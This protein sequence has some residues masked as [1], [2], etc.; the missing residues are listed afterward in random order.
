MSDTTP[1]APHESAGLDLR[2][3]LALGAG[4]G[5]SALLA[6]CGG[7]K[8]ADDAAKP[9]A[10]ASPTKEFTGE[11]TGPNVELQY[12]NGFTGGDGPFMKKLVDTFN[13]EHKNIK[14]TMNTS[15]WADFY[16]KMPAAVQGGKGPDVVAMHMDAIPAN[17]ARQIVVPL[18]DVASG[19]KLEE[20][21]FYPL[22]WKAGVYKDQRYG[23][24]LD[25]H[26]LGM[27]YN[28][29]EM[30]KGNV[31][32]PPKDAA[33]FDAAL[34]ALDKGGSKEPFWVPNRWPAH[35]IFLSLLWQYGGEPYAENGEE[36]TF[37]SEAGVKALTWM[38]DQIKKGYSPKNVAQDSQ[39]T[40][41]KNGKGAITWDGIWQ[42]NDLKTTKLDWAVAPIPQIGDKNAVW[43][44]SHNFCMVK[45]AKP[46]QNKADASRAFIG[47]LS[48]KSKE[49]A[50]A[51]MIPAR[52]SER[53]A[54]ETDANAQTAISKQ[55]DAMRF[56]PPVPAVGEV[57]AQTLEVAVQ[58]A[59]L[60][61]KAPKAALDDNATKAS[62]LMKEN[63]KKFGG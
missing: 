21:D 10:A 56:L 43:A 3:F 40:A 9:P 63:K 32:E 5:A 20:K 55:I 61:R 49:W 15:Q 22:V 26:S 14:V 2:T 39:Y 8:S 30:K 35:L 6:G 44:N 1:S 31:A 18:D 60:G 50:G 27:F 7:G 29:A 62:K 42:I 57:Q 24:P 38:T 51:A 41:F 11:Y 17:A 58:E 45:Q 37:N 33:S 46:D 54:A 28:K 25:V 36:A 53:T 52:N 48:S 4:A 34:Q 47:W 16:A 13:T 19:L 12:W 23:I 59:V